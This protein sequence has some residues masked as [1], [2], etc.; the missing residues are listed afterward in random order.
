MVGAT[1]NVRFPV[2]FGV[3]TR[4]IAEFETTINPTIAISA[5]PRTSHPRTCRT[6]RTQ[7][8]HP[9][10]PLIRCYSQNRMHLR[11][12]VLLICLPVAGSVACKGGVDTPTGPGPIPRPNSTIAYT[13]IGASDAIGWGSS[14]FCIPFADCP[15]GRGYVQ[16][17][18]RELRTRGFTVNQ[19]NLGLPGAVISRRVQNLGAQ[20][21]RSADANMLEQEAPFVT[22][23]TTLVTIFA[24]A[25]DVNT[26]TSALGGGAGAADQTAFINSQIQAFG[27]D[28]ATLL[29]MVREKAPSVRIIVLNLPNM[30]AMPFLAN[31]P[32]QH[33]RA[34]QMLSVGMTT[35]SDQSEH[36]E[37]CDGC[38]SDVRSAVVPG[39]DIFLG[40]ISPERYWLCMDRRGSSCGSDNGP[41]SRSCIKLR[42][43]D[44]GAI[45]PA[46]APNAP[47][48]PNAPNAPNNPQRTQ[49]SLF[50]HLSTGGKFC[51]RGGIGKPSGGFCRSL[52]I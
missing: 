34:A 17:A 23:E 24:G 29:R 5:A 28:F 3:V 39:V 18:T 19:S 11:V 22:A 46:L 35:T 8:T 32:L 4:R 21:S 49:S 51:P 20:W 31:A 15:N 42:P 36:L 47:S 27:Q 38:R 50:F 16:V 30:G 9:P 40:R 45:T 52:L 10:T 14:M 43:D 2:I 48:A 26:I 41:L 12:A 37:W 6:Q 25:N 44:N 7:R 1:T 33:R 13:S